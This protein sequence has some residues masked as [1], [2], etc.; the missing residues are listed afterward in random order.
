M[1]GGASIKRV[2][3]FK[4][5][6]V[7]LSDDLIGAA[8][9]DAIINKANGRLYALRVL[10]KCGLSMQDLTAV[11]CSLIRSVLEYACV[12]F[13]N[14]PQYISH[15]PESIQKRALGII[16]PSASYD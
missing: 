16:A 12:V 8:H 15:A 14:L 9:C 3:C 6:G 4:L 13:T 5:L 1:V 7:H 10:K 11:Y 2:S